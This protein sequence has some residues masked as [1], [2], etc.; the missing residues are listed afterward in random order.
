MERFIAKLKQI[1]YAGP[2]CIEREIPDQAER[3]RDV[4]MAVGLLQKL[5]G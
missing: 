5:V 3:A 4:R 1:H 2:L